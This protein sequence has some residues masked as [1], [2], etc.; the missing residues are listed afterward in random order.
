M[1]HLYHSYIT[2]IIKWGPIIDAALTPK[3][4]N[5]L[6]FAWHIKCVSVCYVIGTH[7]QMPLLFEVSSS[8]ESKNLAGRKLPCFN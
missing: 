3:K 5:V 8:G 1:Y 4:I 2:I 7:Y 6:F